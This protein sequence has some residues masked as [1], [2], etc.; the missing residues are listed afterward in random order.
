MK[1]FEDYYL[2]QVGRGFPVFTGYSH[3]K[4]HGLGGILGRLAR[5]AL[6]LLKSGAKALGKQAIYT[7][8]EIVNDAL[9]GEHVKSAA[10]RRVGQAGRRIATDILERTSSRIK[11]IKRK[12]TPRN[13]R[14]RR[15]K[16]VKRSLDIFDV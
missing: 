15:T 1:S 9:Q 13:V 11:P 5:S 6:P 10:R 2:Q 4:G 3:Q 7:G 12:A 16:R 14:N 8:A